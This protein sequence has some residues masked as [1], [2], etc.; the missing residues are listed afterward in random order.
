MIAEVPAKGGTSV[1]PAPTHTNLTLARVI[2]TRVHGSLGVPA[3]EY[4]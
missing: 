2:R 4:L 1:T 3:P